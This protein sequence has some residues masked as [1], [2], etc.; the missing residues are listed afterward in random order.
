MAKRQTEYKHTNEYKRTNEPVAETVEQFTATNV[1]V[2]VIESIVESPESVVLPEQELTKTF[3]DDFVTEGKN[4]T[5]NV[6]GNLAVKPADVINQ[7]QEYLPYDAQRLAG[8]TTVSGKIRYLDSCGVKRGDIAKTLG[9]RYQHVRNVLI[10][11]L[12]SQG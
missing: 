3:D 4:V 8:I 7:E 9:K 12:K 1:N 6:E 5:S 11:P 2:N 10:T